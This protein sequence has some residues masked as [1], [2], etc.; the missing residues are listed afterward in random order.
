MTQQ[1]QQ[2]QQ[3]DNLVLGV[4]ITK[5]ISNKQ[6]DILL[7]KQQSHVLD[8]FKVATPSLL[9]IVD[10]LIRHSSQYWLGYLA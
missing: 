10:P 9:S 8:Q 7:D 5:H 2:Q 1:E 6:V 3:E 4:R